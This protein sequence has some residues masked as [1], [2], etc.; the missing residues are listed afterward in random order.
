[1]SDYYFTRLLEQKQD[2]VATVCA[3]QVAYR[4]GYFKVKV[5]CPCVFQNTEFVRQGADSYP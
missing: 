4:Q 1:M 3:V 5:R 2:A